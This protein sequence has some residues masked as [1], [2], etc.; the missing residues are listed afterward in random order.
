M[1]SHLPLIERLHALAARLFDVVQG[2]YDT[3]PLMTLH[4]EDCDTLVEDPRCADPVVRTLINAQMLRYAT[5]DPEQAIPRYVIGLGL[6]A[7]ELI[8]SLLKEQPPT[9]PEV[10]RQLH[11]VRGEIDDLC[12]TLAMMTAPGMPDFSDD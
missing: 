3:P 7:D 5:R 10:A 11:D 4:L 1:P 12:A 2:E 6:F 8:P 9:A